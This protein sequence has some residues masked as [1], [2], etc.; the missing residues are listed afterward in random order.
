MCIFGNLKILPKQM[1]QMRFLTLVILFS[2]STRLQAQDVS[3]YYITTS[4]VKVEG[5]FKYADFF[6]TPALKF[7]TD[8]KSD[9][10]VLPQDVVEYG[11]SE[12]KLKF[13][14]HIV[15]I[16]ISGS[17]S[18]TKEPEW[19]DKSL[20][21]NV[22]IEGNANLYSYIKDYKPLFFFNTAAKPGEI[23]QLV[24]KKYIT[25]S[26][27]TAENNFFRQQLYNAVKCEGEN[28]SDFAT[29]VYDKNQLLGIFR[30]YNECNGSKSEV[31]GTK[32]KSDFKYTI[33]AG[34]YNTTMGIPYALPEV[35]QTNDITYGL[36]IEASYVFPSETTEIF[37]RAEYE[38][39]K[40]KLVSS[41]N[42]VYNTTTS[43]YDLNTQAFNIYVGPRYNFLLNDRSK[44]SLDTAFGASIPFG[45]ITQS[46]IIT[47]PTGL[48]YPGVPS[49][50]N[51]EPGFCINFG[52]GYTFNNKYGIYFKCE[53]NRDFLDNTSSHYKTKVSRIGLNLRYTIN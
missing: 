5:Y 28:V 48:Q 3:G 37:F 44:I 40:V 30:K 13:E 10:V 1:N 36:G 27:T 9:Y 52:V 50:Y 25:S 35:D 7:K 31:Y 32:K 15:K 12:D 53:T 34:L 46:T 6:D 4:G 22:L 11:L 16:D 24:Y 26:E 14:K 23:N 2:L 42:Y 29:V 19:S 43:I 17:N 47:S 45:D 33:V 21:L 49:H 41:T 8:K 38:L 18:T 20:F 51:L 39:L